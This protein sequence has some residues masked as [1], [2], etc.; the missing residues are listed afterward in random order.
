MIFN[1]TLLHSLL[2]TFFLFSISCTP[3]KKK[4]PIKPTATTHD[5]PEIKKRGTLTLLTENTSFSYFIYKGNPLGYDYEMIKRFCNSHDLNLEVKNVSD[6]NEIFTNLNEKQGDIIACNLTIT[7]ERQNKVNFTIPLIQTHQV[8]IQRKTTKDSIVWIE[9]IEELE[10]KQIWVHKT[11]SFYQQLVNLEKK[12]NMDIDIQEADGNLNAEQLIRMV[13]DGK[14]DFTIADNNYAELNK[15]YYS[16]IDSHVILSKPE[17]IAWAVRKTSDSPLIELNEWLTD[18]R[19]HKDNTYLQQKYFKFTR[20]HRRKVKSKYSSLHGNKISIYDEIIK[21]EAKKLDWD[22]RLLAALI[23]K[24]SGFD[25]DLKS[26]AGA[27]GLMQMTPQT[28]MKYGID[29]TQT[30]EA[31]IIAGVKYLIYLN[32]YWS[33]RVENKKERIKFVLASY[34]AGHGHIEDARIITKLIG[35]NTVLWNDNVTEG[36]KLKTQKQYYRLPEVKNGYC[37]G[38]Q[39]INYVQDILGT[40][41]SYTLIKE[42]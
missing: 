19:F 18:K 29:S 15:S 17:S 7:P 3:S 40:A 14:I 2:I 23:N 39:I 12:F 9:T 1:T 6:F 5:F 24:E 10:N 20:T 33:K 27:F 36:L 30:E 42:S 22:W 34:N 41:K 31:N 4:E 26:W 21:H 35:K 25:P 16:N 38:Y 28:A 13:A 37:R 32:K 8:L 11:S